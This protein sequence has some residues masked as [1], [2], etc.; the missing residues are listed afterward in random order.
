M[1]TPWPLSTVTKTNHS[2][3]H[4]LECITLEQY[5][6]NFSAV[7][8]LLW[9]IELH[10]S[11][12]CCA[13]C[14]HSWHKRKVTIPVLNYREIQ[15]QFEHKT[16]NLVCVGTWLQ[17]LAKKKK[18]KTWQLAMFLN[19]AQCMLLVSSHLSPL[20][21][22][23]LICGANMPPELIRTGLTRPHEYWEDTCG[24]G[25]TCRS[26][27]LRWKWAIACTT[28]T[29]RTKWPQSVQSIEAATAENWT[30]TVD[31]KWRKCDLEHAN[32]GC[33]EQTIVTAEWAV[34]VNAVITQ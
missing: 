7:F 6:P 22:T 24:C 2:F 14:C 9:S 23:T 31:Q 34:Q 16:Y 13:C 8:L 30:V 21:N 33:L 3:S 25:S 1:V 19:P 29:T 17:A 5:Q 15:N 11:Y 18:K 12:Q 28:S 32:Q 10:F 20:I 4:S 27:Q 26:T